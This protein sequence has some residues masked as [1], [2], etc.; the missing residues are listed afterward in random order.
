LKELLI[1]GGFIEFNIQDL[2]WG[3]SK[4]EELFRV[5]AKQ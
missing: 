1:L 5:F 2:S 4:L 3:F